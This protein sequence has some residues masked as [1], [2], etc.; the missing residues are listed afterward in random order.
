[1]EGHWSRSRGSTR[2]D[3]LSFRGTFSR[4]LFPAL[5]IGYVVV[6]KS[7]APAL[8]TGKRLTD[9]HSAILEQQTVAEFITSGLYERHLRRLRRI[10]AERRKA[11]LN[12][13][14]DYLSGCVEL[15]GD[16]SG[17]HVILWPKKGASEDEVIAKA[18]SRNVGV[19]RI[20]RY[21]SYFKKASRTGFMLAYTTLNE[22]EIREGIRFL[23]EVL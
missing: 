6:P 20:S 12:A 3:G 11:L 14:H 16:G 9:Q 5:R 4:T 7:L 23:A 21:Q 10:N 2:M 15:G 17:T 1:M 18:A 8:T 19:S 22:D 13:I